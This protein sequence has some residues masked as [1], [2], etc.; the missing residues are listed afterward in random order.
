MPELRQF[1]CLRARL[2]WVSVLLLT[3]GGFAA[4]SGG[5][6]V[7]PARGDG[8]GDGRGGLDFGAVMG[9]A[10]DAAGFAVADLPRPFQFPQDHGPHPDFRIEWWYL[11]SHL[12]AEDGARYGVQFTL[13][14]QAL[15]P[16]AEAGEDRATDA[17]AWRSRQVWMAH[18]ALTS[19]DGRHQASERFSRDALGLAGVE[20]EPFAAWL[21]DWRLDAVTAQGMFPLRLRARV[22]DVPR[23]FAIDL[24]FED[25]RGPILQGEQGLSRKS[26]REGNAS[27][28]YSFTR[29]QASGRVELDGRE[30]SL[31]GL[32]WMDREWSS[33]V[34]DSGQV[35]WD[36]FALHLDDGRDLKL[37]Q[38]RRDD[39]SIDGASAGMLVDPDGS[40]QP[41]TA[42]D[43]ELEPVAVWRDDQGAS[44]PVSWRL[45]LPL[46][47]VDGRVRA[48][49]D[50]QLNR[51][52][53]RYWE[54]QVC[55]DGP[56]TGC[57]YLEMT[58]YQP[59][60]E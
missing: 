57:G 9:S 19:P 39:G 41:L 27:Y 50:D 11:V 34:L 10:A 32:G 16:P 15:A 37:F 48:L 49:H 4:G 8:R 46:A 26:E 25:P 28:Y 51:L 47:G 1:G 13:F 20:A 12:Q 29:M 2:R 58:G 60:T 43:F 38:I 23:P 59:P 45:R 14:R 54:G 33:S 6:G 42:A 40:Q 17:S 22:T 21:E 5:P 56:V 3:M 18:V 7:E 55:L 30:T 31:R 53:L 52:A 24:T 36:W 35:G 44:W